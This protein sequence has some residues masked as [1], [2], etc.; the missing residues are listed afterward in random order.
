MRH[1][2]RAKTTRRRLLPAILITIACSLVGGCAPRSSRIIV[3]PD[4]KQV[5]LIEPNEPFAAPWPA[6]VLSRGRYLELVGAEME[7]LA[8]GPR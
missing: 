7:L 6:V 8:R 3:L 4:S 5:F 2:Q 1:G